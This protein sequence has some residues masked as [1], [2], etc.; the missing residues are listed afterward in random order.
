MTFSSSIIKCTLTAA[1][2]LCNSTITYGQFKLPALKDMKQIAD[3]DFDAKVAHP[4]FTN[5][6]PKLLFDVAHHNE[7][8]TAGRFKGLTDLLTNDGY[9]ITNNKKKFTKET[10]AG[11]DFLI[12]THANAMLKPGMKSVFSNEECDVVSQWVADGGALLLIGD[13]TKPLND[14]GRKLAKRFGVKM[15]GGYTMDP[16][17]SFRQ[18]NWKLMFTRQNKL[19]IDHPITR[20]RNK[21]E[22]ITKIMTFG[23]QSL[24]GPKGSKAFLQLSNSAVDQPAF[25]SNKKVSAAGHAQGIALKFGKGR[26]VVLGEA[27]MIQAQVL[28]I[29]GQ[30]TQSPMGMNVKGIDNRQLAINIMHWLSGVLTNNTSLQRKQGDD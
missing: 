12:I 23:G 29:R 4:T 30:G 3:P 18:M 19:L 16:K 21:Q 28:W 1:L 8:W 22:F 20:G 9:K 7:N 27:G 24:T 17:H 25:K 2:V 15:F 10:L 5:K 14:E 13:H 11:F 26:V 6:N